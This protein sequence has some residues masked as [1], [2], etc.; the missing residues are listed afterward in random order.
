MVDKLQLND[1]LWWIGPLKESRHPAPI[2][3][4]ACIVLQNTKLTLVSVDAHIH[5][6]KSDSSEI[7]LKLAT[8]MTQ[9][10]LLNSS[11]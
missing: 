10:N 3:N 7:D 6:L 5:H 11:Y 9:R 8:V 1:S 4:P 2:V